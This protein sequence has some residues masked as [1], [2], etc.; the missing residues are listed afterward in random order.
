MNL[1]PNETPQPFYRENSQRLYI[2]NYYKSPNN[3]NQPINGISNL[4]QSDQP[5]VSS[6][7]YHDKKS[8][9]NKN[10]ESIISLKKD[11]DSIF[12][13]IGVKGTTSSILNKKPDLLQHLTDESAKILGLKKNEKLFINVLKNKSE[14]NRVFTGN[15]KSLFIKPRIKSKNEKFYFVAVI[16]FFNN[17]FT[18]FLIE[19]FPFIFYIFLRFYKQQLIKRM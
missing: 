19:I 16:I 3:V 11:E 7:L 4:I 18:F 14:L 10:L 15:N 8:E 12:F 1:N 13:L 5:K 2:S 17:F 9:K 6:N